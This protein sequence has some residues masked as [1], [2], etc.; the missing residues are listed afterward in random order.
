MSRSQTD[1]PCGP[2][3]NTRS[4]LLLILRI[5]DV[6][7]SVSGLEVGCFED[8]SVLFSLSVQAV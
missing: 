2:N 8:F 1:L 5:L 6:P 3:R 7:Y 4:C